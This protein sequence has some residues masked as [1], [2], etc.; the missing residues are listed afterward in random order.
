MKKTLLLL[1]LFFATAICFLSCTKSGGSSSNNNTSNTQTSIV[2]QWSYLY[3]VDVRHLSNGTSEGNDTDYS[4]SHAGEYANFTSNAKVIN[5]WWSSQTGFYYDTLS[6]QIT[7]DSILTINA[8]S[9]IYDLT[10]GTWTIKKLNTNSLV[11]YLPS[12]DVNP[13]GVITDFY[14]YY[15]K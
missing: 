9:G 10:S 8:P 7:S 6:Y 13:D 12:A 5:C 2:G 1:S 4:G 14:V 3:D 11:Y 15:S